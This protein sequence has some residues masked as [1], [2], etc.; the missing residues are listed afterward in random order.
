MFLKCILCSILN[1]QLDW[2]FASMKSV[3]PKLTEM[4]AIFSLF[5]VQWFLM[6]VLLL[7]W[8]SS[9]I[10]LNKIYWHSR[11]KFILSEFI[12]WE[13]I[14]RVWGALSKYQDHFCT[15]ITI[16]SAT[17][18]HEIHFNEVWITTKNERYAPNSNRNWVE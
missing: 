8:D 18:L 11:K 6:M 4:F 7:R 13:I 14:L 10:K 12:K 15:L 2:D 1:N 3:T 5:S 9:E 17:K 16:H